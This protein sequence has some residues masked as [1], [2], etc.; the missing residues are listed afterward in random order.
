[1]S[2]QSP[3][4]YKN[5]SQEPFRITIVASRY[6][7]TFVDSLVEETQ[8]EI[9]FLAPNAVVQLVRVPGSFEIP[10]TVKLVAERQEP[11]AIIAL[12]VII[13][14]KTAH[15]DLIAD[16]IGQQLLTLS[17]HY[18]VPVIHEVLLLDNEEQATERCLGKA[19]NRGAEAGRT[20]LA[21]IHVAEAIQPF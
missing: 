21:M 2:V 1:M 4:F 9:A 16:A 5:S 3:P 8:K 17:L 13:R 18:S 12:G 7:P 14:G 10:L 19:M 6:N 15:A 20:A 11:D